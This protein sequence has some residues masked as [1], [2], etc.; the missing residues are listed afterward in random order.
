MPTGT[1]LLLSCSRSYIDA[2]PTQNESLLQEPAGCYAQGGVVRRKG[3]V[4]AIPRCCH[5]Q[6]IRLTEY[7]QKKKGSVLLPAAVEESP[8]INSPT[9]EGQEE[10]EVRGGGGRLSTPTELFGGAGEGERACMAL[11]GGE[12]R[13]HAGMQ[14]AAL[15]P[16]I[17]SQPHAAAGCCSGGG[18][19]G[20]EICGSVP[21]SAATTTPRPYAMEALVQNSLWGT[22]L[23]F[24]DGIVGTDYGD[25][26]RASRLGH[27]ELIKMQATKCG[28]S[29]SSDAGDD[30]WAE[31][32]TFTPAAMDGAAS[33]GYLDVVRWLHHNRHEGGT[34]EGLLQAVANGHGDVVEW[35]LANRAENDVWRAL[36]AAAAAASAATPGRLAGTPPPAD[37]VDRATAATAVI[38]TAAA[39]GSGGAGAA[40]P[41]EGA[42]AGVTVATVAAAA[43]DSGDASGGGGAFHGGGDADAAFPTERA[44]AA[45]AAAATASASVPASS[46]AP[47]P[48]RGD[49]DGPGQHRVLGA[50]QRALPP[51][52]RGLSAREWV[53]EAAAAGRAD[54]LEWVRRTQQQQLQQQKNEKGVARA[55]E[56][57][58]ARHCPG[59]EEDKEAGGFLLE[60]PRSALARAARGGHIQVLDWLRENGVCSDDPGLQRAR[61][62]DFRHDRRKQYRLL[63]GGVRHSD[64]GSDS[65]SSSSGGGGGSSTNTNSGSSTINN[66]TINSNV[67]T[68]ATG[69]GG[70]PGGDGGNRNGGG[71]GIGGGGGSGS[72]NKPAA[73]AA[74]PAH[75]SCHPAVGSGDDGNVNGG[76]GGSGGG[77]AGHGGAVGNAPHASSTAALGRESPG[78]PRPEPRRWST[79]IRKLRMM[80][81]PWG[82]G[83]GKE[84]ADRSED[85]SEACQRGTAA[86]VAV[87]GGVAVGGRGDAPREQQSEAAAAAEPA[88]AAA[89]EAAAGSRDEAARGQTEDATAAAPAA[90]PAPAA[91]GAVPDDDGND[92]VASLPSTDVRR[93]RT[94]SGAHRPRDSGSG[95]A[96]LPTPRGSAA[97]PT[98]MSAGAG[99]KF[100]ILPQMPLLLLRR[101]R[102]GESGR[103]SASRTAEGEGGVKKVLTTTAAVEDAAAAAGHVEVLEWLDRHAKPTPAANNAPGGLRLPRFG[104]HDW[105]PSR[106][107]AGS[108]AGP[109]ERCSRAALER[110]CEAGHFSTA[111]WL[112]SNRSAEVERAYDCIRRAAE[113]GHLEIVAWLS[114]SR[115]WNPSA[116]FAG[117]WAGATTTAMDYAAAGGHLKVL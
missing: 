59:L 65:S 4:V 95:R 99:M 73:V 30:D 96:I 52:L 100:P 77:G 8:A 32:L 74:A 18:E 41:T 110:A 16:G 79:R 68:T 81:I 105:K 80:M 14:D 93:P 78:I 7:T 22:V 57:G 98:T 63:D 91:A 43:A 48:R 39:G 66:S 101:R 40:L 90:A 3:C 87:A 116:S 45:A 12:G 19:V 26:D 55:E 54:V 34:S 58:G 111:V 46:G 70:T 53:S 51:G 6:P 103:G 1:T 56:A 2:S 42:S 94:G 64:S 92:T 24:Q 88:A 102:G 49:D 47:L 89:T 5:H 106:R 71:G 83:G 31:P 75:G 82:G 36:G 10:K 117:S 21:P 28:C 11:P 9:W 113:N 109:G 72:G 112:A 107:A 115:S 20:A 60:Y 104:R 27:L 97:P 61:R 35:L 84:R 23:S 50:L 86:A 85:D 17:R 29:S 62:R 108:G 13:P 44:T 33:K 67:T 69:D 25:G 114:S 15:K 38:T 37:G 76:G